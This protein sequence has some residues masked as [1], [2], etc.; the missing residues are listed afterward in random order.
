MR[1][2]IEA[3]PYCDIE[4]E[5]EDKMEKQPCPNCNRNILPC[6]FCFD[7]HIDKN[8]TVKCWECPIEENNNVE[9]GKN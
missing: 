3:C 5:L 1:K 7:T 2:S 4:V 6:T 8:E 9:M